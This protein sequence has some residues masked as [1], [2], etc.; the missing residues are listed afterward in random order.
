MRVGGGVRGVVGSVWVGEITHWRGDA[1][2]RRKR[3][4]GEI[5]VKW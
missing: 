5:K 4:R 2:G 3:K 1:K